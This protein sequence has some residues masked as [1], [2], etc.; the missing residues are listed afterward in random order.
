MNTSNHRIHK[1]KELDRNSFNKRCLRN[2][3]LCQTF[4]IKSTW[5][6]LTKSET[7]IR[8]EVPIFKPR[9]HHNNL[10][11]GSYFKLKVLEKLRTFSNILIR[12]CLWKKLTKFERKIKNNI[13]I[14]NPRIHDSMKVGN[15]FPNDRNLVIVLLNF[16]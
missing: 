15:F 7:K 4:L 8:F 9:N 14:C 6:I 12:D 10:Q 13:Q 3:D 16:N 1:N 5:K 2:W 11:D